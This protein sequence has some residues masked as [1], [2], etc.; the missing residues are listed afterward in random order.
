MIVGG[1]RVPNIYQHRD[2]WQKIQTKLVSGQRTTH[3]GTTNTPLK[4]P[5]TSNL[6][7]V[8]YPHLEF[9]I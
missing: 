7:D 2:Q 4:P 8:S 9:N 5:F 6:H 1:H 3:N